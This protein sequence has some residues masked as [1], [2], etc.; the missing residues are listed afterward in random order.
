MGIL[1][2]INDMMRRDKENR[3][4]RKRNKERL[5]E[6]RNRLLKVKKGKDISNLTIEH[7]EKI[8]KNTEEKEKLDRNKLVQ[9]T[10]LF[11]LLGVIAILI[12]WFIVT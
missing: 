3:E 10:F 12:L 5:H 6:T 11:F 2:C 7:F 1:G 8:R 4:L 9:I